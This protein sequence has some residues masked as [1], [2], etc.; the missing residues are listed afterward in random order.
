[1]SLTAAQGSGST[2]TTLLLIG[3][4][5]VASTR[6][7]ITY[8]TT[9]VLASGF[10]TFTQINQMIFGAGVTTRYNVSNSRNLVVNP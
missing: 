1:M 4:N 3:A 10:C 6:N 7:T 2:P 9:G 8:S 5:G